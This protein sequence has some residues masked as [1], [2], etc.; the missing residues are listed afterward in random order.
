MP[1]GPRLARRSAIALV[2]GPLAGLAALSGCDDGD[3]SPAGSPTATSDPDPDVALV[4]GVLH[5][6]GQA[7]R[8][9]TAAG[10]ADLVTLHRAHIDALGGAAPTTGPGRPAEP[11]AV[12]KRERRLQAHLVEA[13]VAAESGALARLLASMSAAV[14]QR[15]APQAARG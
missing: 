1:A 4:D 13:A 10:L 2:V 11:A 12:R 14:A 8:L 7:L 3:P 9:A 6:L 15:T 5:E